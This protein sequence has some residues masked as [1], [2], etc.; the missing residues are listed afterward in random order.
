MDAKTLIDGVLQ[1]IGLVIL[2]TFHEFGHAWMAM[3]LGDNT[4]KDEGR[5]SLN[6]LVHIDPIGTVLMPLLMFVLPGT[7]SRFLI[8]WA[9]PVPV[10]ISNLRNPRTDDLYVTLAGPWMNLVLAVVL[11][12]LA[13]IGLAVGAGNMVIY[14]ARVADLSLLLFFFNL[15]PIPPLDGSRILR[16]VTGMSHDTYA[17]IAQYGFIA[18]IL[19]MQIRPVWDVLNFLTD[20]TLRVIA[21]W[22][23]IGI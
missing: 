17:S 22:F 18:L 6:P 11:I 2:M 20:G 16:V 15:I 21:H 9:K 19:V 8:G 23:G 12:G 1:W 14:C 5:V 10:N 3:K 7:A 4:A 13:R